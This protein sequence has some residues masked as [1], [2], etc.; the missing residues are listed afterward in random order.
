MGFDSLRRQRHKFI[1]MKVLTT[2]IINLIVSCTQLLVLEK[3][4]L[5]IQPLLSTFQKLNSRLLEN[6]MDKHH[7]LYLHQLLSEHFKDH[8]VSLLNQAQEI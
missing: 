3:E 4:R 6:L 8:F 2:D 7:H 5:R 1:N